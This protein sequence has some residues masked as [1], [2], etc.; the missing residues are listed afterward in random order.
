MVDGGAEAGLK[1]CH[2]ASGT[3]SGVGWGWGWW[4]TNEAQL[5]ELQDHP[6]LGG[7]LEGKVLHSAQVA[8]LGYDVILQLHRGGQ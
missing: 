8:G 2:P 7:L 6:V 1:G 3:S 4:P 5:G